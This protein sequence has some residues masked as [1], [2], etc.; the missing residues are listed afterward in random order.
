MVDLNINNNLQSWAVGS[1][2]LKWG[3][4][5]LISL[6][7][8]ASKDIITT[9]IYCMDVF[10]HNWFGFSTII[11]FKQTF[12]GSQEWQ[13]DEGELCLG[14][15]THIENCWFIMP[16]RCS[17]LGC[18]DVTQSH[19]KTNGQRHHF[20][21]M[22]TFLPPDC[23]LFFVTCKIRAETKHTCTYILPDSTCLGLQL[24]VTH[25]IITQITEMDNLL[26]NRS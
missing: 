13:N 25:Y 6:T 23:V 8:S 19:G 26:L 5:K 16:S 24:L 7:L 3:Q 2:K 14:N 4:L 17:F 11:E 22:M 12:M 10:G 9:D 20:I 18:K 21:L 1:W 15:A